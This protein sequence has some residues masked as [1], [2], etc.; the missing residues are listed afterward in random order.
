M[1]ECTTAASCT[2]VEDL[3]DVPS[4]RL[5]SV[6]SILVSVELYVV[7]LSKT[8][9]TAAGLIVSSLYCSKT[10][11]SLHTSLTNSSVESDLV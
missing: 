10:V 3:L 11:S 1:A 2:S 5:K 6:R 9:L 4:C 7:F 8:I